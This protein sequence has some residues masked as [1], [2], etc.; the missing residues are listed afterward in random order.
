MF[1]FNPFDL[2]EM[3]ALM[4]KYGDS[5]SMYFGENE[6]GER[7]AISIFP[8]RIVVDTYQENGWCRINTYHRDGTREETYKR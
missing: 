7:V 1:E 2:D 5:K 6:D 4:D 8:D 3:V